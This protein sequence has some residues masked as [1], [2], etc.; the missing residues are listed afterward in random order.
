MRKFC[1]PFRLHANIAG[2]SRLYNQDDFYNEFLRDLRNARS[3]VVIESPFITLSRFR[4]L[5]PV[6]KGLRSRGLAITIN[7]RD[8]IEHDK[9]YYEQAICAVADLQGAGVRV[10][11]TSRLHRKLAIIDREI[12]WEG[13]LNILSFS[14]SCEIM[15]RTQ[16]VSLVSNTLKFLRIY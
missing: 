2:N 14:D 15:R 9:Q 7:T 16:D 4:Q 1:S 11:F 8:P 6:L 3:G 12:L 10:L 13:S 5:L